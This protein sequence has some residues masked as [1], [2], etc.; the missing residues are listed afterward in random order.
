MDTYGRQG[1]YKYRY[2]NI[3]HLIVFHRRENK[4]STSTITTPPLKQTMS[5]M[6]TPPLKMIA[7]GIYDAAVKTNDV[8]D[9]DAAVENDRRRR[10][11]SRRWK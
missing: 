3:I 2:S 5:T 7:I 11:R 6:T 8:N 10:L 1:Y 9:D 4:E